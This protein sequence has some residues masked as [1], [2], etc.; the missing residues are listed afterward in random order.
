MASAEVARRMA[1]RKG[2]TAKTAT[3]ATIRVIVF[4]V[5]S[6]QPPVS[7]EPVVDRWM[8]TIIQ[9]GIG[10]AARTVSAPTV[11]H[12][13]HRGRRGQAG[14]TGAPGGGAGNEAAMP[15]PTMPTDGASGGPVA[16]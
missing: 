13:G 6:A 7:T 14:A 11:V 15:L 2:A 8:G 10:M 1:G 4:A 12:G 16:Q 9:A 3:V 5:T